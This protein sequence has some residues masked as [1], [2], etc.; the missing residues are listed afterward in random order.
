MRTADHFLLPVLRRGKQGKWCL[1]LLSRASCL[2]GPKSTTLA[3]KLRGTAELC[4]G[5]GLTKALE[6]SWAACQR[7]PASTT[8]RSQ[9]SAGRKIQGLGKECFWAGHLDPQAGRGTVARG[10]GLAGSSSQGPEIASLCQLG[11]AVLDGQACWREIGV[12]LIC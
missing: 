12:L 3:G 7:M 5:A 9:F 1:M 11:T 2:L 6:A 8:L 10:Q 4:R